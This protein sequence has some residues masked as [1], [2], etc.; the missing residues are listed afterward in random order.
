LISEVKKPDAQIFCKVKEQC[1]GS[2]FVFETT[3]QKDVDYL[4]SFGDEKFSKEQ[5]PTHKFETAGSY[6]VGLIVRSK[7][8]NSALTKAKEILIHVIELPNVSFET[9][10]TVNM[11][12]PV[13]SFINTTDKANKWSWNL[14]D[15]NIS[16]DKDPY[17]NYKRKGYYNVSLTATNKEG[18]I[19]TKS[20]KVHIENDYNLLAPNSFTPNGDGINDFFIPEALKVMDIEFSMSVYSQADGLLFETKSVNSPW[21]GMNNQTGDKCKEGNYIWV[22]TLTNNKGQ[23]EQYKGAVL[24]LE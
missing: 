21:N 1:A 4:W 12:I 22:V 20:K 19:S 24:I 13:L 23:T 8:D 10:E 5:N 17:H 9:E 6:K 7:I 3:S 11:G 18:C 15:G 16:S 2:I 14:G